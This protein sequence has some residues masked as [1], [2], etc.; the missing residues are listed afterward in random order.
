MSDIF[1]GAC[2]RPRTPWS[3]SPYAGGCS[4][5][6]AVGQNPLPIAG[7][8]L[9]LTFCKDAHSS[10]INVSVLYSDADASTRN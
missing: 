6:D 10:S 3:K 1:R 8:S 7:S 5:I 4:L 2:K 9:K